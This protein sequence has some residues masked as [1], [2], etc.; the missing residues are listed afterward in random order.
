MPTSPQPIPA[1]QLP[2]TT[3]V[4]YTAPAFTTAVVN[5][6]SCNN[7]TGTPGAT[8]SV[9]LYRVED[10][11]NPGDE[12]MFLPPTPLAAGRSLV[13]QS[14]LG[15]SLSPGMTIQA[16]ASAA[17]SITVMGSVYETVGN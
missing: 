11:G 14:A 16:V 2:I 12:N 13:P 17:D 1:L 6:L 3:V 5:N 7:V 10:G 15:L 4:V 8:V 9:T